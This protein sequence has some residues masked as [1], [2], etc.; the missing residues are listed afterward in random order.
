MFFY[1]QVRTHHHKTEVVEQLTCPLCH[2]AGQVHISV[3]QKYMWVLG[4]IA[5][6]GKYAVA[7]CE[8]CNQYIPK[9][10][11]TN[12]M[13]KDFNLL[14]KDVKTPGRLY[15]GLIVF[16]LAVAAIIGVTL[17]VVKSRNNKQQDN[18]A[19]VKDAIA[20]PHAGDIFQI[21]HTD[22]TKA[23]YT[24][25]KVTGTKGDSVFVKPGKT[26]LNDVKEWD[27]I[28]EDDSAYEGQTIGFSIRESQ[29]SDMFKF[30]TEPPQYG[31]VWSVYRDGKL[32]KKY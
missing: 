27:N 17:L 6:S 26:H 9:V 23:D 2:T 13:D 29:A 15:R 10:R 32:Y 3:L 20:H 11:W 25:F 8:H 1:Y 30:A 16:P 4:P 28:P 5:P 22:G 21:T 31:L 18:Q 7:Y 19:L 24:Y 14:K 12:E